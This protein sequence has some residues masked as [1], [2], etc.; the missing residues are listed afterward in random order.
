MLIQNEDRTL[1]KYPGKLKVKLW[2]HMGVAVP[3]NVRRSPTDYD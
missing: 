2:E 1:N 3:L